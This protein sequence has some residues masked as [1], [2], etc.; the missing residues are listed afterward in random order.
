M[1]IGIRANSRGQEPY[2]RYKREIK[3]SSLLDTLKSSLGIKKF[4]KFMLAKVKLV[5]MDLTLPDFGLTEAQRRQLTDNV[6]VIINAAGSVDFAERLDVA[7]NTNVRAPLQLLELATQCRN[8]ECFCH[9]SSLYALSERTG[10]IDERMYPSEHDWD[11][12]YDQILQLDQKQVELMQTSLIGRFPNNHCFSKRMAEEMLVTRVNAL[13]SKGKHIP[14]V[15]LRPSILA[16]CFR[17]PMPGWTDSVKLL[18][19]FYAVGGH[20]VMTDLP[21][22]PKLIGD[23][24]PVDF[25]ASQLLASIVATVKQF[26]E[27]GEVLMVTH[28]S[29]SSSN[30]V[31]WGD[32]IDNLFKYYQ[33][34]PL[35]R[36][37]R[38]PALRVHPSEQKY[39]ISQKIYNEIP[40][41]AWF[42]LTKVAG[43][44]KTKEDA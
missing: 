10:F 15:I 28:A 9:V 35:D 1:Y 13:A 38:T 6:N 32:I 12:E 5:A 29:T 11:R 33:K 43:K 20:G 40:A 4:R 18:G 37:V 44:K 8:F 42:Y 39:Q 25:V 31:T 41:Q 14:L 24:I 36:A 34:D 2:D 27:S 17:E 16:A 30:G 7:A 23:Q 22:N 26:R 21:I 19:G 3:D